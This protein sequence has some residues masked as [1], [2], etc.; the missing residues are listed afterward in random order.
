MYGNV[1][2]PVWGTLRD[3]P[4]SLWFTPTVY[5]LQLQFLSTSEMIQLTRVLE[6][7]AKTTFGM[8]FEQDISGVEVKGKDI[9]G[10][11]KI[12]PHT[13]DSSKKISPTATAG[14][15]VVMSRFAD[16]GIT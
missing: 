4:I 3:Q 15:L 13:L 16:G 12:D 8:S 5:E 1:A 6:L 2:H 9:A 11:N 7:F 14:S 10:Q